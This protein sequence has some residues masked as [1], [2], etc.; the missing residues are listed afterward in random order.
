MITF[1]GTILSKSDLDSAIEAFLGNIFHVAS[2]AVG[3]VSRNHQT[4]GFRITSGGNVNKQPDHLP[5]GTCLN[6]GQTFNNH[7][8]ANC[9]QSSKAGPLTVRSL[10]EGVLQGLIDF[11]K[12][13]YRTL[14][15]LTIRPGKMISEYVAGQRASYANPVK[16]CIS[17]S[18]L[19]IAITRIR[20]SYV[21]A[22]A[23]S[24]PANSPSTALFSDFVNHY[25]EI[26][27]LLES[28]SHIVSLVTMPILAGLLCLVYRKSKRSFADHMAFGCF[29]IGHSTFLLIAILASD[30]HHYSFHAANAL[31]TV[32]PPIYIMWAAI[33]F[34]RERFVPGALKAF[35]AY[36][37]YLGVVSVL[38]VAAVFVKIAVT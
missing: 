25:A 26:S 1:K 16:Y 4:Y 15:G 18:V 8:C 12:P 30:L 6:C 10:F 21:D 32:A 35:L 7:F 2:R 14:I 23:E 24:M 17:I 33:G 28:Y 34:N 13:L 11:D 9:G 27:H 38:M 20:G 22:A 37:L 19:M 36:G 3:V 31:V 5:T 29:A